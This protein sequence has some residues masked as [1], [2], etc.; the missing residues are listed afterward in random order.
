[1]K[2]ATSGSWSKGDPR[3]VRAGRR[4]GHASGVTRALFPKR[5]A[6][7]KAGYS[8]GYNRCERKWQQRIAAGEVIVV[9]RPSQR[10]ES[11][12]S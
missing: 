2:R 10:A 4:G 3:A 5:D 9:Q 6:R 11:S 8:A 7:V 1:M 12:H